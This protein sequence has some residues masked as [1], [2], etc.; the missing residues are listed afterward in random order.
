VRIGPVG[1]AVTRILRA[2]DVVAH[3]VQE[4][5]EDPDLFNWTDPEYT[6]LRDGVMAEAQFVEKAVYDPAKLS[7]RSGHVPAPGRPP[8]G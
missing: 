4:Y 1:N 2:R 3:G 6:P 7:V 8:P 5:R